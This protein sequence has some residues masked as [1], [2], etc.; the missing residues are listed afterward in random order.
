MPTQR[1][2]YFLINNHYCRGNVVFTDQEEC[3]YCG[4]SWL[5]LKA[6]SR[7]YEDEEFAVE[8]TES[9]EAYV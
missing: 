8:E 5:T 7:R 4:R 6:V 3:P 9:E 2:P 1:V